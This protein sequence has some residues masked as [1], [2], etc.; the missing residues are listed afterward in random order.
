MKYIRNTYCIAL[1]CLL[2][3]VF[4]ACSSDDAATVAEEPKA[5][6]LLRLHISLAAPASATRDTYN[7]TG[8]EDGDG[9][10]IG[11]YNE[12]NVY[13]VFLY[14]FKAADGINAP[15]NT[16]VKLMGVQRDIDFRPEML[17]TKP[18]GSVEMVLDMNVG[19]YDFKSS[20]YDKYIAL[21]NLNDA[22]PEMTLGELRNM[23][24]NQTFTQNGS[25]M[26]QYDRFTM[27]NAEESEP[28]SGKGTE[29]E[30]YEIG[31]SVERHAA[32]IDFAYTKT[33]LD[34]GKFSIGADGSY[35][36]KVEGGNDEVRLTHVRLTNGMQS[37][38]YLIKRLMAS[39][40]DAKPA[41]LAKEQDPASKYVVE[42][43]TWQKTVEA[44]GNGT[45]PFDRWYG[46]S[47]YGNAVKYFASTETPWFRIQDKVHSGSGDAFTDGTSLDEKD[48]DWNYYVVGYAN[49]NTM[50]AEQTLHNYT[51]GLVLK[52]TYVP[53]VLYKAVDAEAGTLTVDEDYVEGTTFWRWHDIDTN[54]DRYFSNEEAAQQFSALYPHS[55]VFAYNDAQ[56]YYNVWLRHENIIDDPT[57]TT[58]EFG[59]VRNN[60]YRV[61]VEFTGI[62]M[63]DVPDDMITPEAI[64]MFIYVRKWNLITHPEIEI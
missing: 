43:T 60:I 11:R 56:C 52:A 64:R 23:L 27:A 31:I 3:S 61:N 58:M 22:R 24:V 37:Q 17:T 36:Y 48:N 35:R 30:P 59:I 15:D 54:A 45:L 9:W 10:R 55:V 7:P 34:A 39:E 42:P 46:D 20:I 29:D 18:D 38:P 19:D 44:S 57:T 49:E 50:K 14:S 33:A 53:E 51:T 62:G 47:W 8:G 21:I 13:D 25:Q 12:N 63:P 16:P 28:I 2:L 1:C 5:G 4:T 6:S 26:K 32:R 40:S 41:Y